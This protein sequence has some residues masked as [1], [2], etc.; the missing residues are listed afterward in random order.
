MKSMDWVRAG[1]A[2]LVGGVGGTAWAASLS[3]SVTTTVPSPVNLT[4][5]GTL[6]WAIWDYRAAA[7]GASGAPLNRKLGGT[8]IGNASA[9]SGTLRGITGT[10]PAPQYNYSDGTSPTSAASDVIGAIT[11]TVLNTAGPGVRVSITGDPTGERIAKIFVTGFNGTG[12]FTA[13][14]NGAATYTDSSQSYGN[15]RFPAIYTLTYRPDS[16]TDLLQV[17]YTI[18]S[19]NGGGNA[20]MDLQAVTVS[21]VPVP[22]AGSVVMLGVGAVGLMGRGRR[23]LDR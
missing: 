17:S 10:V 13:A 15:T 6:D 16:A 2:L 14:L 3:G 4:A 22:E 21:A 18:Q 23:R 5:E 8:A 11:S 12:T 19:V 9:V 7:N 20:N 1:V